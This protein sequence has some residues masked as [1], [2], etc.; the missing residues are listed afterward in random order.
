VP[1]AEALRDALA[2]GSTPVTA[3]TG[4]GDHDGSYWD[5][6]WARYLRF[7]ARALAAC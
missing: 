1:G 6:N 5:R 2:R 3:R 7:Y 4:P